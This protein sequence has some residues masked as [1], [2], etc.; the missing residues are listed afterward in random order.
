MSTSLTG[1]QKSVSSKSHLFDLAE[2]DDSSALRYAVIEGVLMRSSRPKDAVLTDEGRMPENKKTMG[3]EL[4]HVSPTG[5]HN[6][7]EQN[8]PEGAEALLLAKT[9]SKCERACKTCKVCQRAGKKDQ[10]PRKVGLRH[11]PVVNEPLSRILIDCVRPLPK[12]TKY[13]QYLLT[14]MCATTKYVVVAYAFIISFLS[15][16]D[17]TLLSYNGTS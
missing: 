7:S 13:N 4:T 14:M 1:E 12:S 6:E 2:E 16:R 3:L 5:E 11:I 9:A 8:L 15:L 17:I 10:E